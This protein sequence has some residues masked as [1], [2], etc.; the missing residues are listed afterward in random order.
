MKL[1]HSAAVAA[2]SLCSITAFSQT[3]NL[4]G[5]LNISQKT[6]VGGDAEVAGNLKILST[7]QPDQDALRLLYIDENGAVQPVTPE[8][9]SALN[10]YM[11]TQSDG[12]PVGLGCDEIIPNPTPQWFSAEGVVYTSADACYDSPRVGIGT[13]TPAASLDVA[14]QTTMLTSPSPGATLSVG[15]TS[16]DVGL[17]ITMN[18]EDSEFNDTA[19]RIQANGAGA[20]TTAIDLSV[21]S[22]DATLI[23]ATTADAGKVFVVEGDGSLWATGVYVRLSE[24]FPD[25][26]FEE[27]YDLMTLAE[28][29]EYIKREKHLPNMPSSTEVAEK[30]ADIGEITRVLVE[31]V[32]ELTLYVLELEKK[33]EALEAETNKAPQK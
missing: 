2:L 20:Q 23:K 31:K 4:D 17:A 10:F 6:T 3:Y 11:R 28:L 22:N 18:D 14:G 8:I 24:D 32:E 1:L 25:Y 29:E 13:A 19:I 7:P 21:D 27:G 15:N 9:I 16:N 33:I 5:E 30:G 26:V 12:T